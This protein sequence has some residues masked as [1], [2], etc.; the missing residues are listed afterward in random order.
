MKKI[1]LVMT[2]KSNLKFV[3][4]IA[5]AVLLGSGGVLAGFSSSYQP[6][7]GLSELAVN[8]LVALNDNSLD[9]LRGGFITAENVKVTFGYESIFMV[10]GMLQASTS[11]NFTDINVN[12]RNHSVSIGDV[13]AASFVAEVLAGGISFS[14]GQLKSGSGGMALASALMNSPTTISNSMDNRTIQ[15]I[16]NINLKIEGLDVGYNS[17]LHRNLTPTLI[18]S[19][20]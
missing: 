17:G 6:G 4:T 5:L 10:D 11:L 16:Q 18:D 12:T 8:D 14:S 2:V 9:D 19:L 3:A 7:P 13:S 15:Y 20:R 1:N